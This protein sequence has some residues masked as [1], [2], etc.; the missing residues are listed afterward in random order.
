MKKD[1]S[2]DLGDSYDFDDVKPASKPKGA[3]RGAMS[4][5]GIHTGM[6]SAQNSRPPLRNDDHND[7]SFFGIGK[8]PTKKPMG[9]AD[10]F[11][12][13]SMHHGGSNAGS[14]KS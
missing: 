7:D 12:G 5:G 2:D 8:G 4:F 1:E 9:R 6:S 13:G 14:R 11:G 3:S 10:S